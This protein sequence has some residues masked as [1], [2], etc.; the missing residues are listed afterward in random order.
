MA[1]PLISAAFLEAETMTKKKANEAASSEP[2]VIKTHRDLERNTRAICERINAN[3]ELAR[4]VLVNAVFAFEDAGVVMSEEVK[5]HIR[6]TLR[7]PKR[8]EERRRRLG[9]ELEPEFREMKF[10]KIPRDPVARAALLFDHL[11]LEPQEA[12]H[13]EALSLREME[14]YADRHPLVDKLVRYDRACRGGLILHTKGSYSKF[15]AGE[16]RHQW[17][18]AVRFKI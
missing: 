17:V 15:K 11:G 16:R 5:K 18:K 7:R 4:L 12:K 3:P 6:S 8:I 9:R 2:I 13:R 14:R 1:P 10:S